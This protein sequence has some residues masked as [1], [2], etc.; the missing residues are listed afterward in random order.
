MYVERWSVKGV[1]VEGWT[2]ECMEGLSA[3]K[4]CVWVECCQSVWKG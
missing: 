2:V 1:C 3:V 4:K